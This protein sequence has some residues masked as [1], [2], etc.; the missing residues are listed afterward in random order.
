MSSLDYAKQPTGRAYGQAGSLRPDEMSSMQ[1]GNAVNREVADQKY[2]TSFERRLMRHLGRRSRRGDIDAGLLGMRITQDAIANGRQVQGGIGSSEQNRGVAAQTLQDREKLRRDQ[3]AATDGNQDTAQ[4][5]SSFADMARNASIIPGSASDMNQSSQPQPSVATL[6]SSAS[7]SARQTGSPMP[8][9]VTPISSTRGREVSGAFD[10]A[11][12][13]AYAQR[14]REMGFGSSRPAGLA[15]PPVAATSP[16]PAQLD[17]MEEAAPVGGPGPSPEPEQ[18]TEG[19]INPS[20]PQPAA[21]VSGQTSNLDRSSFMSPEASAKIAA[22]DKEKAERQEKYA[23]EDAKYATEKAEMDKT[24]AESAKATK[25]AKANLP[26]RTIVNWVG[27]AKTGGGGH[28]TYADRDASGLDGSLKQFR[29]IGWTQ[30]DEDASA[31]HAKLAGF[32]RTARSWNLPF[33][34]KPL[35][36][37][38]YGAMRGV[39]MVPGPKGAANKPVSP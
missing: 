23:A 2:D 32:F 16:A 5:G 24:L 3:D 33:M 36:Q 37:L 17:R 7:P 14:A 34:Q 21:P 8:R 39:R 25:D 30:D 20:S 15:Q 19:V 11:E 18:I 28:T 10:A 35:S 13:Q 31:R 38:E 29:P 9:P 27:E 6:D 1:R 12:S 26:E 22:L 4:G